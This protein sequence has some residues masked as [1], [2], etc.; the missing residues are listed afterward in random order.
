MT[1]KTGYVFFG[2]S[3]YRSNDAVKEDNELQ[4]YVNELSIDGS[5]PDGGNG[6]VIKL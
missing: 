2:F 4:A 1:N 3:Y 6:K 5:G